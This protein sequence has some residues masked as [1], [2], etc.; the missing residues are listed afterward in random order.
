MNSAP[1]LI[2]DDDG[3]DREFIS[4]AW[5]DL[6]FKN[7]LLF[8]DN[9][10]DVLEYLAK[11]HVNPFLIICDVNIPRMDGFELKQILLNNTNTRY[12]SIPFVF[13][14][15]QVSNAQIQKAYDLGVNGF[16]LKENN[17]NDLKQSLI[18]IVKYWKKSKTPD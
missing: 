12:R 15:T 7:P 17:L 16:F 4:D 13:W 8:F 18:D 5:N 9:G 1:I 6:E 10:N 11:E 14:S 3:E 2:V